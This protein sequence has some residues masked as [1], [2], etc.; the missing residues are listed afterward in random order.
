MSFI[1]WTMPAVIWR[2]LSDVADVQREQLRSDVIQGAL[3][4]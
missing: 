2:H 3:V 1:S 4:S